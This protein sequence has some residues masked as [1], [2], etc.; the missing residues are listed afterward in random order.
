MVSQWSKKI[1]LDEQN[2]EMLQNILS[3][4]C[5]PFLADKLHSDDL[6]HECISIQYLHD[7]LFGKKDWCSVIM[8][9]NQV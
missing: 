6:K 9:F 2:F 3:K 4:K 5:C 8:V 1:K 7:V